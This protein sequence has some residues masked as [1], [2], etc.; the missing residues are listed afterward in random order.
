MRVT[1]I[2]H[3]IGCSSQIELVNPSPQAGKLISWVNG[4]S[5]FNAMATIRIELKPQ[6]ASRLIAV[7]L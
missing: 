6:G 3:L 1:S 7:C 4:E 5:A 2:V